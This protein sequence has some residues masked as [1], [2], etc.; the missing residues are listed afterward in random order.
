MAEIGRCEF[1]TLIS[2]M[3]LGFSYLIWSM[4]ELRR[5]MD[6]GFK[7]M[8][9]GFKQIRQRFKQISGSYP[10][11]RADETQVQLVWTLGTG[12]S[13]T[14]YA[15]GSGSL[16]EFGGECFISTAGHVMEDLNQSWITVA[17]FSDGQTVYLDLVSGYYVG[18]R[19]DVALV[20]IA[21]LGNRT[22]LEVVNKTLKVGKPLWG[23]AAL[24]FHAYAL[25]CRVVERQETG[26]VLADCAGS[27]GASGTGYLNGKGKMIAI[28][29]GGAHFPH[30]SEARAESTGLPV[31][32]KKVAK[33]S[34]EL[35]VTCQDKNGSLTEE[36][37]DSLRQLASSRN[38]VASI[39]PAADL[40]ELWHNISVGIQPKQ[41]IY[42]QPI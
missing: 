15:D 28:H 19:S 41:T 11:K 4:T 7:Q 1:Y 6:H 16:V 39:M 21:C 31:P 12:K 25:H 33:L 24:D 29:F 30:R 14:V 10:Y 22:G 23:L 40:Y 37:F 17:R 35:N 5:Q 42:K 27:H 3:F 34:R 32:E 26:S 13:A 8:N 18:Q 38:Q 2:F 36:C 9:H 20:P